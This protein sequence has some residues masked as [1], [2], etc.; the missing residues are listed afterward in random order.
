[1]SYFLQILKLRTLVLI[2]ITSF[3]FSKDVSS[4]ELG[5]NYLKE[6]GYYVFIRHALAPGNGDPV[7]FDL[8]NC[9]TQRNLNQ[10]GINQAIRIGVEF[11]N[12]DIPISRV[13]TSQW[14]RCKDTAFYA[15]NNYIEFPDLNSTYSSKFKQNHSDQISSLINYIN[16]TDLKKNNV[17]FVTHYVII[18]ALTDYYPDS[19]EI[20]ITDQNLNVLSTIKSVF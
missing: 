1:M 18:G 20:V 19:A 16:N 14:C 13:L 8:D 9:S 2:L 12:K 15:F 3:V 10:Q 5:W 11:K 6:G 17:I 4:N 7:N